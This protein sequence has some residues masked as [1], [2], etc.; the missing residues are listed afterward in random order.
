M[1]ATDFTGHKA[2]AD[3]VGR[4]PEL[5]LLRRAW[6]D[7][8][9]GDVRIVGV[10]GAPGIGKTALVRRFLETTDGAS[11]VWVSGDQDETPSPWGVMAQITRTAFGSECGSLPSGAFLGAVTDP[12]FVGHALAGYLH[13]AG[14]VILVIDDAHWADRLSMA[15]LRLAARR[16]STDPVLIVVIH[17]SPGDAANPVHPE[18]NT[19]FDDGWRRL[20]DSHRG[21]R[22][23][24]AGLP[25]TDLVRLAV[26]CDHP[27]LSPAG[28]ARLFAHTGGH[29][30]YVR[31]LLDEVP[32]HSIVFGHGSLPA[33][34]DF[35]TAVRSR[36][37][38]CRSRTR[39]LVAAGAV[40]GRRFSLTQVR[41]LSGVADPVDAVTEAIEAGL[42]AEV[43]GSAGHELGFTSTLVRGLV[44]HD[45]GPARRRQL[46]LR[47]ARQGGT[48]VLWHR[49][50]AAD[51][52][53]SA[54]AADVERAADGH[55]AQGELLPA[56]AYLRHALDLT[57]PGPARSR[58]LLTALEVLLVV[59]DVA[60]TLR[61][62]GELAAGSG[63]WSD[64]VAGYQL[65][66]TGAVPEAGARLRR[67]M[68]AARSGLEPPD[69]D[70]RIATQ[71][72]IIGVLTV[73]YQ[74]MIEYGAAA[75]STAREPWVAAFAWFAR[76]VGLAV[77]GRGTEALAELSGV[78]APGAPSGLDGLVARGMIRLWTDDLDG[79]RRDL[80]AAVHR[81]TRGE[82]LRIG[83]A[84]GFLGEVEYRRGALDEAVLHTELAVGDAEENDRIWDYALLHAQASYPLAAQ[85]KWEQA[86]AHAAAAATWARQVGV[87]AGLAYAAASRAAIAQARAD[88]RWLLAAAEELELIY[89]AHE[90]GTHLSGPARADA[91]SQ[92]GRAAEAADALDAFNARLA[93]TDRQST[94][95]AVARVRAQIAAAE[96]RHGDALAE[97]GRALRL[98]RAVGL[99][100]E[101]ARIELLAGGCQSALGRR[102]AAERSLWSALRQFTVMG[103]SAYV[104]QTLR[105]AEHAGLSMDAPPAAFGA[106]TPAERAVATLVCQGLSNRDIA[107]QLVLS[108]KTV[109]F[110]LTNV[111]RRLDVSTRGEL[112][113]LIEQP[114]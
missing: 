45:L 54:L 34:R 107:Q 27:G 1:A 11:L 69:L 100:L 15:A 18:Q 104:A 96:G 2:G 10:E 41:G 23:K 5:A 98:V 84:L 40:L 60:T 62:K 76:S 66:L 4:E 56:A 48:G 39:D 49:I 22:L 93:G 42:L 80:T 78:D 61:Y 30:L 37:A 43:P 24:L 101:A 111:Y 99:P 52:P 71:L 102:A 31:H 73:S 58:R 106:L 70:A 9:Q 113:G 110:H 14:T 3:F 103:A 29:P 97:C 86:Q 68:T 88:A 65:L 109:E 21:V 81:A 95:G 91:L 75:V 46:H 112:R 72:A 64:Y 26:A 105:A 35:A 85:G 74:E 57:P 51:G 63:A 79:A 19:A 33:P 13:K 20:L 108:T 17:Q 50:A 25:P 16:L 28:A 32:M 44:Y 89:P 94:L 38:S 77:A 82:T 55:L 12:V 92:L 7:A 8:R 114:P 83:Q 90:P 36:L 87:P 67:A 53:D 6:D 59:G 47:A